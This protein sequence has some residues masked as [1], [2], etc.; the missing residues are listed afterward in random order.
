MSYEL[1]AC[2]DFCH[3]DIN[4]T[5]LGLIPL[6]V[7][8][9]I[10]KVSLSFSARSRFAVAKVRQRVSAL[11]SRFPQG[12][13]ASPPDSWRW[14]AG[15]PFKCQGC[16]KVSTKGSGCVQSLAATRQ[17]LTSLRRWMMALTVRGIGSSRGTSPSWRAYC[18][19][20]A[21][22]TSLWRFRRL[23]LA[24]AALRFRARG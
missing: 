4:R 13:R 19:A 20:R 2:C 16:L 23:A 1:F 22:F 5:L 14:E 12:F 7:L 24:A 8:Q 6:H 21:A 3:S 15:G 9:G 18:H 10:P 11:L 17:L